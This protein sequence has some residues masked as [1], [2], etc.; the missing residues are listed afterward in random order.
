MYNLYMYR[1]L[2]YAMLRRLEKRILVQLP[3]VSAREAMFHH[4]LPPILTKE[5]V[6][7]TSCVDYEKAAAVRIKIHL[8]LYL[9]TGK[10]T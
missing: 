5:P 7:I 1:D 6:S 10:N 8:Y 4:Y 2:D 9:H 3:T